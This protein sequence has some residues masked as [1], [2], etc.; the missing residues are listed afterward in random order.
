MPRSFVAF[1]FALTAVAGTAANQGQAIK[2]G[3]QA[4]ETLPGAFQ[5]LNIN[6]AFAGRHHC[7]VT[8]FR[9]NPV[10]LVFVRA[11]PDGVDPEVKKLLDAL[12]KAADERHADT[13][14]EAVAVFLTPLARS[15]ATEDPKDLKG[16]PAQ[17]KALVDEAINREKLLSSL[18]EVATS[19][20]RLIVACGPPESVAQQ[21]RLADRA[22]VTVVLYAR[23]RVFANFAF[24]EGQLKQEGIDNV[25]KSVDKMLARGKR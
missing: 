24:A 7:L 13:G 12:D 16:D 15:A 3:P 9:L 25:L 6:G 8:E 10:A 17:A 5:P 4:D 23:H 11:Q 22:D 1:F 19:F 20:K 14:L 21:Y 18:K 2:S